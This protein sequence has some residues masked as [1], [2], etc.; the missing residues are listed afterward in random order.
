[1]SKSHSYKKSTV[2]LY[3]FHLLLEGRILTIKGLHYEL[4]IPK[5]TL[6]KYI[7]NIDIFIDITS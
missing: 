7:M 3:I 6:Y 5:N 2:V 4:E 1:M